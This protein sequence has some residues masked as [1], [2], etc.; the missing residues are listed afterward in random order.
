M[1]DETAW[2]HFD[3]PEFLNEL[4]QLADEV[5]AKNTIEGCLAAILIYHQLVDEL[6]KVLLDDSRLFLQCSVFP[7]TVIMRPIGEKWMTGA[8]IDEIDRGITFQGKYEI[9]DYARRL[10]RIRVEIVHNLTKQ[11]SLASITGKC[12]TVRKSALVLF[13]I[14]DEVHSHFRKCFERYHVAADSFVAMREISLK[15]GGVHKC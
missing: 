12:A 10:N 4:S 2:P 6:L 1:L 15:G 7:S 13:R 5:M 3:R 8:L 11:S 14:F 9:L